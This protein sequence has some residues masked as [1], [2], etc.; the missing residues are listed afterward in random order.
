V[1]S[2]FT[3]ASASTTGGVGYVPAPLAGQQNYLLSG[4]GKWSTIS[5][6]F[7]PVTL[8]GQNAV[9]FINIPASTTEITVM[10]RGVTIPFNT[11]DFV[12]Q[13][14][15]GD[16]LFYVPTGYVGNATLIQYPDPDVRAYTTGFG[17]W[18]NQN[19]SSFTG[20][21]TITLLDPAT[22]TWISS[23]NGALRLSGTATQY[24]TMSSSYISLTGPVTAVRAMASA[25]TAG[26][27][28][29]G[30]SINVKYTT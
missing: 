18:T 9:G 6:Y 24:A 1:K 17:I 22:N 16:P 23:L 10:F 20:V 29:G 12:V 19:V 7:S 26:V 28:F 2:V 15:H 30:G 27:T 13:L 25:G 21:M 8:S 3:S 14:G 4:S 5:N 11:G